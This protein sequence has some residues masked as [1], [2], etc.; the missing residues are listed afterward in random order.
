MHLR[1]AASIETGI[2]QVMSSVA[3]PQAAVCC[4]RHKGDLDLPNKPAGLPGK[5][6]GVCCA[7]LG[8]ITKAPAR[9]RT[10]AWKVVTDLLAPWSRFPAVQ[11]WGWLLAV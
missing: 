6:G 9:I 10:G 7:L 8:C 11:T 1:A 4:L 3:A 2:W 5:C